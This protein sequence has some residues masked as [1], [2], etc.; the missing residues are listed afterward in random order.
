MRLFL[1][2]NPGHGKV[3]ERREEY[4]IRNKCNRILSYFW[5]GEGRDFNKHFERWKDAK[6]NNISGLR[7][8][9]AG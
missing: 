3:G 6:E 5:F 1:A 8:D 2:G 9:R 7:D 4:L